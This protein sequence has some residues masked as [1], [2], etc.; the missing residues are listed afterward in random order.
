MRTAQG[1][2]AE[3]ASRMRNMW[4]LH[5]SLVQICT[6]T[7][8]NIFDHKIKNQK[9]MKELR[10]SKGIRDEYEGLIRGC[11]FLFQFFLQVALNASC[12]GPDSVV[13]TDGE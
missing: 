6:S 9:N 4:D 10:V 3:P 1:K 5:F 11:P 8:S 13:L 12:L 7:N 2:I